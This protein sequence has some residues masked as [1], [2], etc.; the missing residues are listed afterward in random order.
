MADANAKP[1]RADEVR[2]ERRR[3]RGATSL[4][5]TKLTVDE[6]KLDRQNFAYR[7]A[8]DHGARMP[9][10]HADDW[11]PAPGEA[12]IGSQGAGTVG[13]KIGGTD[14]QGKPYGMVLMR[15][16]KDWYDADQKEKQKP[17]DAIDA[18]IRGGSV[19]ERNEPDLRGSAY[20]PGQNTITR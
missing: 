1:S 7:W 12:V 18:S 2:T 16:R 20:T 15:K 13:T 14:E 10:L 5:G 19:H 9:Q 8:K 6:S 4:P 3:K 17:L 11:D